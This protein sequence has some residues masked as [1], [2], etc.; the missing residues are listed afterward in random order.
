MRTLALLSLFILATAAL[1]AENDLSVGWIARTPRIDYVW[2]SA[3]PTVEG[4]PAAGD[5][6]TWVANVRWLGAEPLR[7]V[8]YR[9]SIDGVEVRSGRMDFGAES[10]V[11]TS[12]PWTWTFTRHE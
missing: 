11:Q 1:G 3:N 9:W 8:S 6:V 2:N 10:L 4:W 12:L 5:T 7:N